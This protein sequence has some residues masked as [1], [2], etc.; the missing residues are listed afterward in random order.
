MNRALI[1]VLSGI[2]AGACPVGASAGGQPATGAAITKL[3]VLLSW[4]ATRFK[5]PERVVAPE[6]DWGLVKD[7]ESKRA[8]RIARE[9]QLREARQRIA[10][11]E[12]ELRLAR[13]AYRRETSRVV[14]TTESHGSQ[15]ASEAERRASEARLQ[16][17]EHRM[18]QREREAYEAKLEYGRAVRA[19]REQRRR[20]AESANTDGG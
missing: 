15:H 6:K 17:A 10:E 12:R 11:R 14:Q 19:V 18:N 16:L 13:E 1:L 8:A 7:A 20:D 2:L 3:M 4:G 5:V 9:R